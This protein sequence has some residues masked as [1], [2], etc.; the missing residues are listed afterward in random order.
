MEVGKSLVFKG[1]TSLS[2]AWKLIE[3]FSED[4]DLAIDRTFLKFTGKLQSRFKE[5]GFENVGFRVEPDDASNGR[6]STV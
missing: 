4:V 2:K 5:K 6:N 3:R 1:G